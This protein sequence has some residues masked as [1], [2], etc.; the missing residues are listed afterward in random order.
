MTTAS[1]TSAEAVEVEPEEPS[2]ENLYL[3]PDV[4]KELII[5]RGSGAER[6]PV[7]LFTGLLVL[8]HQA[9]QGQFSMVN[10]VEKDDGTEV[11]VHCTL[12]G[13]RLLKDGKTWVDFHVECRGDAS[14]KN[15][16]P[17]VKDAIKRMAETRAMSRCLRVACNVGLVA[18]EEMSESAAP[19]GR[20]EPPSFPDRVNRDFGPASIKAQTREEAAPI[21]G[22]DAPPVEPIALPESIVVNGKRYTRPQVVGVMRQRIEEANRVG[23]KDYKRVGEDG[24][25][26]D[27]V[28][29]TQSLRKRIEEHAKEAPAQEAPPAE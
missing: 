7:I 16:G 15:V 13:K 14:Q 21:A 25:L 22:S 23:I 11:V 20:S 2:F 10:E 29:L 3:P 5:W 18:A 27:I 17:M 8:L 28:A 12:S 19:S 4:P 9:T 24:P 1:D 26:P 6:R